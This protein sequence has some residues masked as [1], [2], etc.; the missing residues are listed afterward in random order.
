MTDQINPSR[1]VVALPMTDRE[2]PQALAQGLGIKRRLIFESPMSRDGW[3]NYMV[4]HIAV[5]KSLGFTMF[6]I[7]VVPAR[8]REAK[9]PEPEQQITSIDALYRS[10]F[11]TAEAQLLAGDEWKVAATT[12]AGKF[13]PSHVITVYALVVE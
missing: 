9:K 6:E 12:D 5:A 11:R 3:G 1:N 4:Q 8:V 2:K 7:D 10:Y 13:A